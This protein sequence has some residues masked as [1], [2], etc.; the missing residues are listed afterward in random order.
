MG[1]LFLTRHCKTTWNLEGLLQGTVDQPLADVGRREAIDVVESFADLGVTVVLSS[2]MRRAKQTARIYADALG[3]ELGGVV[4]GLRELDHGSWEGMVIERLLAD[5]GTGYGRWM[6]DPS[7]VG[8]PD[9]AEDVWQAQRRACSAL[10]RLADDWR[11]ERVLVVSHKHILALVRCALL[12]L[13]FAA[14]ESQ[15]VESIHPWH[16]EP[17]QLLRAQAVARRDSADA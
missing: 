10:V 11:S 8:I 15:I 7:T 16:V 13:T 14:F 12:G 2:P 5:P 3:V 9:A 4:S 17:D 6:N 1:E